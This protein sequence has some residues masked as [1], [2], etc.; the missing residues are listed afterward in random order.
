MNRS[1]SD[2]R[3]DGA[4]DG[5]HEAGKDGAADWDALRQQLGNASEQ[6]AGAGP[7]K[8]PLN[9]TVPRLAKRTTW[10]VLAAGLLALVV[11]GIMVAD[12]VREFR[13]YDTADSDNVHWV[14]SQAEVEFLEFQRAIDL[15]RVEGGSGALEQVVEEF[16]VFYSRVTTLSTGSLY[17][18]LRTTPG[19]GQPLNRIRLELDA[20]IPAIDGAR[21][22]LRAAL[23]EL[24]SRSARLRPLLREMATSGLQYF[25]VVSDRSRATVAE[26]LIRLATVTVALMMALLLLLAHTRRVSLQIE[27]RGQELVGAYSRL[28]TI[29]ETALDA[30]VVTDLDGRIVSFNP[31][32]ERIF[33]W[34]YEEVFGRTIGA[35]IVPDHLKNAHMEGMRRMHAG[36]A[37][38][39]VGQGRMRMEAKRR[40]GEVFPVEMALER[41]RTGGQEIIVGFLRDISHRVAQET[42]LV[43][44]RDRALAG[45]KAKSEF[46]AMMTHEIRTPLNGIL[47]NLSLLKDTALDS[48]QARYMRAM[49]TSGAVLMSHVDA[50]LDVARFEAG[51]QG[52][53]AQVVNLG[54]MVDDLVESQAG[55][56]A[57]RGN[58]L[59]WRWEGE[60]ADWVRLDASRLSQ[61]LLNLVGNAIKFTR[62]GSIA[63]E[64][65][66]DGEDWLEIRVID[67]G[68]GIPESDQGRVFEDFQ[69]AGG[70][71]GDG[72]GSGTG[73]G[74][75]IARRFVEAMG[76][77]IG[78]ESE[79]GAGSV[80]WLR[81][82]LWRVA[83]PEDEAREGA[84]EAPEKAVG[85]APAKAKVS[86]PRSVLL[87]EDN[88]INRDLAHEMLERLGHRVTEACNGQEAVTVAEAERFDLILMDIRMPVMDGLQAT[89][90]IR[91]G[92]GASHATP[93]VALSAN[94]LP[95]ARDRFVAAG[96]S[97]FLAKPVTPA[98]LERAI[99]AWCRPVPG[100]SS[101]SSSGASDSVDSGSGSPGAAE[102]ATGG[103]TGGA[104]EGAVTA[105]F[106]EALA[107][108]AQATCGGRASALLQRYLGE[109]EALF[110]GLCAAG[111]TRRL[112]EDAHRV[113]GSAAAFGQPGLRD[114]L[115]E[116][117]DAALAGDV[118]RLENAIRAARRARAEA[119]EPSLG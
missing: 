54:R 108:P 59:R 65:E 115:V 3:A 119:P 118:S 39:V 33:G 44:A 74:L 86:V 23:P 17:E 21:P 114:A 58:A 16:D 25:A 15:A 1:A 68:R 6:A 22:E 88:Q 46:L 7:G 81:L 95:E 69:T 70:A 112:A 20:M 45:E 71:A 78:V 85:K 64:L 84:G 91:E 105:Q 104:T 31:A 103:A 52:Q 63:L 96:M 13:H 57:A 19:F 93:V 66:C 14:L 111:D 87:V 100:T 9:G 61:V 109:V 49:E 94:V 92:D 4:F 24:A 47:G 101:G 43:E 50:V 102:G 72:S 106:S 113:A 30:V 80:F 98:D 37:M 36:G 29:L 90:L 107:V 116:L 76:G 117:E 41:V 35:T 97:G 26:T 89:R 2:S 18:P 77:E 75:G 53:V 11:I 110:E 56:A 42:E 8:G 40:N 60:P 38:H 5:F 73:L 32:A 12:I 79:E 27:R 99:E 28:N 10:M 82:P 55:A 34:R 67:T 62:D 83:P 48:V 51:A